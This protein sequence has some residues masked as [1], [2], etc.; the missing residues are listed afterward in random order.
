VSQLLD[1]VAG[2][3]NASEPLPG[4]VTGGQPTA[5]QLAALKRAGCE[6]V[7]DIREP[8]E[9]RPYPTPDAVRAAG[10]EYINVPFGHG[11]I[12]DG[13]FDRILRTVRELSG[14]K[15]VMFHCSS[16][17]RVGVALIPY[18]MLDKGLSE[19]DAVAEAMRVGMRNAGLMQE[20]L[21]YVRRKVD[22]ES[23]GR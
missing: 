14:R 12:A 9:P 3:P 11:E 5:E 18:L 7:L 17:N 4:I 1:A 20:A 21:D 22:A 8:M 16:G 15:R 2:L 23:P 10:L 19:S 6:V 13:T